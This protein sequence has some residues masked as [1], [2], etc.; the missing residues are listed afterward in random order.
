MADSKADRAWWKDLKRRQSSSHGRQEAEREGSHQSS[1][2]L[3][4]YTSSLWGLPPT[5]ATELTNR[6]PHWWIQR[7]H[8]PIVFQ[9]HETLGQRGALDL[10]YNHKDSCKHH[11]AVRTLNHSC[12]CSVKASTLTAWIRKKISFPTKS[13]FQSSL[14]FIALSTG[15]NLILCAQ[16]LCALKI[17][18][19]L[20]KSVSDLKE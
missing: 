9:T 5:S 4:P 3:F 20:S 16:P 12:F 2:T 6:W 18:F 13:P 19:I 15:F 17:S 8:A 10:N 1:S 11:C 14:C 7:L